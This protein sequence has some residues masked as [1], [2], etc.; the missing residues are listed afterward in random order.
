MAAGADVTF[1]TRVHRVRQIGLP[2]TE[3]EVLLQTLR[4][5]SS[6]PGGV[7]GED[8]IRES[9]MGGKESEK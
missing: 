3:T 2:G 9:G 5:L 6:G 1:S 4:R 7:E 8:R